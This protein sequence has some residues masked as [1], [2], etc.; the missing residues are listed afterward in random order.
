MIERLRNSR[1]PP[2]PARFGDG[3]SSPDQFGDDAMSP[4]S[5]GDSASSPSELRIL[6]P[7]SKTLPRL[8]RMSSCGTQTAPQSPRKEQK[9]SAGK[10]G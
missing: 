8:E 10:S 4:S 3:L 2:P 1:F 9:V 7:T 5:Y 6:S